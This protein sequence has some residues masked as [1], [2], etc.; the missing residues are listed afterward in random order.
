M[1]RLAFLAVP[2][3]EV[4]GSVG[5]A[6]QGSAPLEPRLHI[7]QHRDGTD[8]RWHDAGVSQVGQNLAVYLSAATTAPGWRINR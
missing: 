8:I 3:H 5:I 6:R 1:R 4:L 2:V 7:G